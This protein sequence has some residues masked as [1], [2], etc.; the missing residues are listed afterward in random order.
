MEVKTNS[1]ACAVDNEDPESESGNTH[2]RFW[3][4]AVE[5]DGYNDALQLAAI[6]LHKLD[7]MSVEEVE[8]LFRAERA[9]NGDGEPMRFMH[10]GEPVIMSPYAVI[11][12]EFLH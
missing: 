10:K 4:K 9:R 8:M 6:R 12:A 1:L 7:S 5:R 3:C 2:W 11:G